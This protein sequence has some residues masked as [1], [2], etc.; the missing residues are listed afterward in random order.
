MGTLDRRMLVGLGGVALLVIGPLLPLVTVSAGTESASI[1]YYANGA[2][3][4][5]ILLALAVIAAVL[6][7]LGKY[8]RVPIIGALSLGLMAFTFFRLSSSSSEI[9][10]LG[11]SLGYS[12][13]WLVM[14]AGAILLMILPMLKPKETTVVTTQETL[15]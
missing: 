5:W 14:L 15:R 10:A 7:F 11:A 12:Y 13:G 6:L 4:G 2:G 3:D 9:R 1:N 8:S